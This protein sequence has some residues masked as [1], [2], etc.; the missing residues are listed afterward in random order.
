MA[1]GVGLNTHTLGFKGSVAFTSAAIV[2][3]R[4]RASP[5]NRAVRQAHGGG[6]RRQA[7]LLGNRRS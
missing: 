7:M 5:S 4:S 1:R 2:L 6:P 3:V